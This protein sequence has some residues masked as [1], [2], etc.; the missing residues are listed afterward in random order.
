[1]NENAMSPQFDAEVEYEN[2]KTPQHTAPEHSAF[3][4][5]QLLLMLKQRESHP[6]MNQKT[7]RLGYV[8]GRHDDS[9]TYDV[10]MADG[11]LFENVRAVGPYAGE[12]GTK[13]LLPV[14]ATVKAKSGTMGQDTLYPVPGKSDAVCIVA[15]LEGLM[16][17]P[18]ILGF[19]TPLFSELYT[20]TAGMAV[21][22][23]ESGVYEITTP[24]GSREIH[25]PDGTY[26][27]VGTGTTTHNMTDENPDW[28]P[29]TSTT[30][31]E[32]YLSHSSGLTLHIDTSGNL[33]IQTP[34]SAV[35]D[36][37]SVVLGGTSGSPVAREGDS[38]SVTVGG[39][40]YTGTIT[41]GSSK[42]E[43]A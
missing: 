14:K 27:R 10:V 4:D 19:L 34:G 28:N 22:L 9:H 36:A 2:P 13:Y 37:T 39:T 17:Q 33:A 35:I 30:K 40:V 6:M 23:H 12:A 41:S 5:R 8:V 1:M 32:I 20:K 18:I 26:L 15:F 3:S 24:K 42:V 43:S 7:L 25:F 29:S 16:M 31:E 38:V 21:F 11:G